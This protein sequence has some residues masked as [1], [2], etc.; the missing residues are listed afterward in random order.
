MK[1]AANLFSSAL[2]LAS[3]S[4]LEAAFAGKVGIAV[5]TTHRT[6]AVHSFIIVLPPSG[7]F[8]TGASSATSPTPTPFLGFAEARMVQPI[9]QRS[10][11]AR[12]EMT[13]SSRGLH[14]RPFRHAGEGRHARLCLQHEG[15]SW[16]PIGSRRPE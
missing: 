8:L 7:R 14:D 12:R 10:V 4:F 3:S 15:K 5:A 2:I 1:A 16:I 6:A 13:E 11:G 9:C